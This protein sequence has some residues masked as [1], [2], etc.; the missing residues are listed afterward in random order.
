MGLNVEHDLG[1][2]DA[3]IVKV[4]SFDLLMGVFA[5]RIGDFHVSCGDDDGE[6]DVVFLHGGSPFLVG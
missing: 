3:G 2:N 4:E 6:V 5:D 1:L